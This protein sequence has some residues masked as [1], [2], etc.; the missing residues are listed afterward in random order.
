MPLVAPCC[1]QIAACNKR[2]RSLR[3][4][5]KVC[6]NAHGLRPQLR[7]AAERYTKSA[8]VVMFFSP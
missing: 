5:I 1:G 3:E 4:R 2:S 7:L 6:A 8:P